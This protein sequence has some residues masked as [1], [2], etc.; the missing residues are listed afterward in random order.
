MQPQSQPQLA[1]PIPAF[2]HSPGPTAYERRARAAASQAAPQA[3]PPLPAGYG[4]GALPAH[5]VAAAAPPAALSADLETIVATVSDR[6]ATRVVDQLYS[7]R[8]VDAVS[9]AV[10]KSLIERLG[11]PP[12]RPAW[13]APGAAWPPAPDPNGGV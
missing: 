2:V 1:T 10:T 9:A 7:Q 11:L 12:P 8:T 5:A 4:G 13:G 3:A 6:V